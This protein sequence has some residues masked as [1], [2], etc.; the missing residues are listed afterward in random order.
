MMK[1]ICIGGPEIVHRIFLSC[2]ICLLIFG[3]VENDSQN[4]RIAAAANTQYAMKALIDNFS[5]KTGVE[6]D[7]II[8][9]SGKH[10]AQITEGAPFDIFVAANMKYPEFIYSNGLAPKEPKIYA[11]GK[12]VLWSSDTAPITDLDLI[13]DPAIKRIALANPMTAP[14]GEA[15]IQFL[16]NRGWL[17]SVRH[18]LVYGENIAQTNQFINSRA[19]Q[20]GFTALSTVISVPSDIKGNWVPVPAEEYDPIAQGVVLIERK[21]GIKTSAKKFYSYLLS[22]EAARILE[23]F[24]YS[25]YE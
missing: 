19:A 12:L 20:L 6:C 16:E 21:Q 1:R 14:Y 22:E 18:K 23:D 13:L 15:A 8:A 25:K 24:G 5:A 9:S 3:C 11:Y 17:D 2:T 4:I 7:L 10:T